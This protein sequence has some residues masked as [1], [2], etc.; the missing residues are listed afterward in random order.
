MKVK[1]AILPILATLSFWAASCSLK[2]HMPYESRDTFYRDENACRAMVNGCYG[3]L[4]TIFNYKFLMV[5]EFTSD[6]WYSNSSNLDCVLSVTPSKPEFGATVWRQGYIGVARCNEAVH[7]ICNSALPDSVKCPLQAEARV[8]RALYYYTL[9]CMFD[10][11]PFYLDYVEGIAKMDSLRYL[12]RTDAS[13]IRELLYDDLARNALPYFTEANGLKGRECDVFQ[14]RSGY[15]LSLMLMA[16][17]AIWNKE[18]ARCLEPLQALEDLYGEFN[19]QNYPLEQT[20]WRYKNIAESIF[21]IQHSYEING[22][23]VYGNCAAWMSPVH[24]GDGWYDGVYM[25]HIGMNIHGVAAPRTNQRFAGMLSTG[26]GMNEN[27]KTLNSIFGP[28]PLTYDYLDPSINR[29]RVKIDLDALASGM[30]NGKKLDRRGWLNFGLGN[31]ETG[32]TFEIVSRTGRVWGG[33]KFWCPDMYYA[34]DDNNYRVFRYADAVLMMAE[35]WCELKDSDKAM[36]YLNLVRDRAGAEP[37]RGFTSYD[38]LML[39]IRNERAR[40]LTGEFQRKF[41]L[42]RW[43]IWYEQTYATTDNSTLKNNMRPC[44]RY[45]P[46]P[47]TQCALTGYILDNPEYKATEL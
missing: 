4:N 16:K 21:E 26:T 22:A 23:K 18:W 41:D 40:E 27:A 46:I 19:S 28:L 30:K 15:A 7:F 20:A 12:P 13:E 47:D 37:I 11:V 44:H 31:L 5:T 8:M 6:T 39:E 24:S 45:Y 43:G 2:E 25:P 32:E 35:C 3:P 9:T 14:N 42:V 36:G 34:Y 10:G 1:I 17:F 29:Y 33:P 38:D